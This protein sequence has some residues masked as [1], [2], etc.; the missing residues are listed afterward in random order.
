MKSFVLFLV[1]AA[2]L[3]TTAPARALP[4]GTVF[5]V[6]IPNGPDPT[7]ATA[8][9][10]MYFELDADLR[11]GCGYY[12]LW[13]SSS[14]RAVQAGCWVDERKG[15]DHVDC[16][17]NGQATFDTLVQRD[18]RAPCDGFDTFAQARDLSLLVGLEAS[19]VNGVIGLL[20]FAAGPFVYPFEATPYP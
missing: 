4:Q 7:N 14:N 9:G 12:A 18:A 2:S 5:S 1:C 20:Q 6:V 16:L 19:S 8:I 3:A 11:E 13:E 15:L 17:A 10:T